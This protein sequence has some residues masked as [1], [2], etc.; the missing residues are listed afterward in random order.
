[1]S[2]IKNLFDADGDLTF[3]PYRCEPTDI[4]RQILFDP[5]G[6][7]KYS[8]RVKIVE[9]ISSN[10]WCWSCDAVGVIHADDFAHNTKRSYP[11]IYYWR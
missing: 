7:L 6:F 10:S 9:L 11:T 5:D 3:D 4:R 1:M 2:V 8:A